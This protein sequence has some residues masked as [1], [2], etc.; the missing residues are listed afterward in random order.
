MEKLTSD[1]F[2]KEELLNKALSSLQNEFLWYSAGDKND[3]IFYSGGIKNVTGYNPVEIKLLPF[4]ILSLIHNDDLNEVK[5]SLRKFKSSQSKTNLKLAYRIIHREGKVIWVSESINVERN[6]NGEI[7]NWCGLVSDITDLKTS[8]ER[9]KKSEE[10]FRNLNSAKDKFISI[11]SHDLK[12]PFTSILGFVEILLN[13]PGLNEA[14][15][16]EYLRYIYSSSQN[17]LQLINY[18]LDWSRLHSGKHKIDKRKIPIQE[19]IYNSV[20]NTTGAAVRK[21]IRIKV[22]IPDY[23][24]ID[25]DERLITQVIAGLL[26][27]AVKFSFE[28]SNVEISAGIFNDDYVEI[29]IKDN[30]VGIPVQNKEKLF[31]IE[32]MFS[33]DGTKG[34]KGIGLGLTLAKEIIN[35]HNGEIWFYSEEKKGTE[36]H[37]TLPY[38]K[39]YILLVMSDSMEKNFIEQTIKNEYPSFNI[40]VTNNGF[41][42]LNI[43]MKNPPSLIVTDL[44]IPFMNGIQF[45]EMLKSTDHCKSIPVLIS[46]A[47]EN[48]DE[49]NYSGSYQAG[50]IPDPFDKKE[51]LNKINLYLKKD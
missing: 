20:F 43:S 24:S 47:K 3:E 17:Q 36:F 6:E 35:K 10:Y 8:E 19:I 22:N 25:A 29:I 37:I 50:I 2:R 30:G 39:D 4:R 45:I 14:D 33:T 23:L 1:N 12:S 7:V 26:I 41:E 46:T 40:S 32:K 15:R 31:H 11:L 28:N 42:A 9:I 44:N 38:L 21:N 5:N 49:G 16:N 27:N 48:P 51:I 34:E 13:E 18:L